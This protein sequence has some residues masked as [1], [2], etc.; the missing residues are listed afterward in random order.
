MTSDPAE[1][2][3]VAG[4]AAT[5]AASPYGAPSSIHSRQYCKLCVRKLRRLQGHMRFGRMACDPDQQALF[6]FPG[7]DRRAAI[8]STNCKLAARKIETGL[9]EFSGVTTKTSLLENRNWRGAF[10][11]GRRLRSK[12]GERQTA[13]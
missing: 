3:H 13:T 4:A 7:H 11:P 12:S 8:T 2:E 6:G 5:L 10:P 1:A 9:F